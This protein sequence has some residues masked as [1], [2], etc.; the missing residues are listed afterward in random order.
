VSQLTSFVP[1]GNHVN[2][3]ARSLLTCI[4]RRPDLE[5]AA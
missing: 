3:G 2:V 1:Y 5:E 4:T